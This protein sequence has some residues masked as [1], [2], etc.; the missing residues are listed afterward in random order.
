MTPLWKKRLQTLL[1][2]LVTGAVIIPVAAYLVGGAAV[3]PYEGEGGLAGYLGTIYRS[4]LRGEQAALTLILTPLLITTIWW[5][6]LRFARR[7]GAVTG[8]DAS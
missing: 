8:S 7:A 4:A 5:L 2:L 3:G 1:A 6:S